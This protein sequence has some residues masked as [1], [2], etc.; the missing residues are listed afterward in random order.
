MV[1]EQAAEL[2]EPLREWVEARAAETGRS[3]SEVLARATAAYRLLDEHETLLPEDEDL[4][5]RV[6]ELET[7]LGEVRDRIVQL[8]DESDATVDQTPP[9]VDAELARL[10]SRVADVETT[11]DEQIQDVRERVVQVKH[12]ADGKAPTDHDHPALRADLEHAADDAATA[13]ET[14]ASALTETETLASELTELHSTVDGGFDNY[15]SILRG[16]KQSTDDVRDRTD[17]LV[18]AVTRLHDRVVALETAAERRSNAET[19]QR[20]AARSGVSDAVCGSCEST[21]HLGLLGDAQ[22]PHCETPFEGVDADTGLLRPA[23]LVVADRPALTGDVPD[24]S[25]DPTDHERAVSDTV[26]SDGSA[27]PPD[28][29]TLLSDAGGGE[30]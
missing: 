11:L 7:E 6:A 25:G 12:E 15:E 10:E 30:R 21:V 29:E 2:P 1:G 14:A 8:D 20:E 4:A 16:L 27:E 22:C 19:L 13:A 26:G 28:I 24:A 3:P 5:D 18:A 17:R 9:E 23:R